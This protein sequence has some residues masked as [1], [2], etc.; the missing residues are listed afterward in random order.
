MSR[1]HELLCPEAYQGTEDKTVW[2]TDWKQEAMPPR[3]PLPPEVRTSVRAIPVSSK[4][5]TMK[6]YSI[7]LKENAGISVGPRKLMNFFKEE[8]ALLENHKPRKEYLEDG[9]FTYYEK[10]T[11]SVAG[12]VLVAQIT[13][14]GQR[15]FFN[16]IKAAF[17]G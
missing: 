14:H 11:H 3:R 10:D 7:F 5:L 8:G 15:V 2:S 13:P 1:T 12:V 6:A 16:S 17:A 4:N 9:C